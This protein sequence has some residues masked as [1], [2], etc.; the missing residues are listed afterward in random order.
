MLRVTDDIY[1]LVNVLHINN[2]SRH[3]HFSHTPGT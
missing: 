1:Q 3:D 2:S